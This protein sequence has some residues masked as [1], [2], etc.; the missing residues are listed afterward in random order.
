MVR[1]EPP[2]SRAN[3]TKFIVKSQQRYAV[4]YR[5]ERCD[6]TKQ[7]QQNQ[8]S[9]ICTAENIIQYAKNSCLGT[10]PRSAYRLNSVKG[11]V[12]SKVLH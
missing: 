1:P 8:V 11:I 5:V 3:E 2:V 12:R 4:V 9:T 7:H 6:Y 10:V